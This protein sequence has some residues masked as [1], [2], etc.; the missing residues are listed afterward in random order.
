MV[1]FLE[2]LSWKMANSDHRMAYIRKVMITGIEKYDAK[3]STE[4]AQV[5]N[6]AWEGHIW[7][8]RGRKYSS[9]IERSKPQQ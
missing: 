7:V 8:A 2:K 5:K 3:T 1:E 4:M 9:R 6:K